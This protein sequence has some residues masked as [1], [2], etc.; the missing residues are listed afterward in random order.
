M[1][2]NVILIILG[3]LALV[4]LVAHG[5]WANR[6]EKTQFF[7]NANTFTRDGRIEH[8]NYQQ[9]N[10]KQYNTQQND[11]LAAAPRT[12]IQTDMQPIAQ[13]QDEQAYTAQV[14]TY[15]DPIQQGLDFDAPAEPIGIATPDVASIKITLPKDSEISQTTD[16]Y[17]MPSSD[18]I[19]IRSTPAVQLTDEGTVIQRKSTE[20]TFAN[21]FAHIEA[22][23]EPQITIQ[24]QASIQTMVQSEPEIKPTPQIQPE[25]ER[26]QQD[27]YI[28]TR[29]QAEPVGQAQGKSNKPRQGHVVLYVV[30]PE[31]AEFQGVQLAQA[32]DELGLMY[33]EQGIYH[34]YFDTVASPILFSVA[35]I[36]QPG[37]FDLG[38]IDSFHTVGVALFMPLSNSVKTDLVNFRS[39][40]LDAKRLADSLGGFV[41]D[42]QQEIFTE[43]SKAE[44]NAKIQA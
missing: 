19:Q 42:E 32:L 4:I 14:N 25:P 11:I 10:P 20:S 38:N 24:S 40:E 18:N 6:R 37:T 33:S 27:V 39:M 44:Y 2:L 41:L 13:S 22:E 29:P 15:A 43:Q 1:D 31:N 21:P 35:N 5:L 3:L 34:R 9:T 28:Q 16:H 8:A 26:T 17:E 30:A 23:P 7:K 12:S 36:R